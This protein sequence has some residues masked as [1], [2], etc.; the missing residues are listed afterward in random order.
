MTFEQHTKFVKKGLKLYEDQIQ[1]LE[2]LKKE[3][4]RLQE[5]EKKEKIKEKE[6]MNINQIKNA[7]KFKSIKKM[8]LLGKK[9]NLDSRN[10]YNMTKDLIC[11]IDEFIFHKR[12]VKLF[13][14]YDSFFKEMQNKIS[15]SKLN[16]NGLNVRKLILIIN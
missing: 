13:N 5:E 10:N 9:R 14:E 8:K 12:D 16:T 11:S 4:E 15:E 6:R 3:K 1:E 7:K 2:K